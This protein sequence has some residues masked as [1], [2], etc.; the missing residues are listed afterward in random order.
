MQAKGTLSKNNGMFQDTRM[1]NISSVDYN[2]NYSKPGALEA[3]DKDYEGFT[4]LAT[5]KNSNHS[6]FN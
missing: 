4:S 1:F 6:D 2:P 5:R 3:L